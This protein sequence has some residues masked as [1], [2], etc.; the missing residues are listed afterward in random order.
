MPGISISAGF[1]IGLAFGVVGLLSGFCLLSSLRD[2]WTA[3]DGRKLRSYA[4]A[5]A[6]AILGT[7]FIAGA[8]IVD[9]GKSIYLQPSF[10]APLR[11][12]KRPPPDPPLVGARSPMC[13]SA[14]CC[15]P[16]AR[17]L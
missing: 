12:W 15:P 1:A 9:I 13:G 6:V 17:A 4:V 2:W 16:F 5:L 8:G 10:S 14:H 3:H 7:Q 11:N